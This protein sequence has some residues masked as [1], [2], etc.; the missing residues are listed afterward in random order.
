MAA[1]SARFFDDGVS[2]TGAVIA[3]RRTYDLS[4]A[5]GGQGPMPG[6]PLFV[7]THH[8]PG[9]V[10]SGEP[11]SSPTELSEPVLPSC[12]GVPVSGGDTPVSF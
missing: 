12:P 2:G 11:P 6:L 7:V 4:E 3:G 10:P 9:S 1:D 5:W 8:V